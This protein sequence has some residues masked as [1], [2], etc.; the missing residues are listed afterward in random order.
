MPSKIEQIFKARDL[1]NKIFFVLAMLAFFR[2]AAHIPIP[3]VDTMKLRE[4]FAD[5]QAFGLLNLFSG[6]GMENFSIVTMGV[7]PYITASIIFQLLAMIVPKLEEMNK[8]EQGRAK[9]NQWTRWATIPIAILQSYSVIMLLKNSTTGVVSAMSPLSWVT[10][11]ATITAG[12]ILLMW[13]GELITEKKIGNGISIMIFAGIVSGLLG[14]LQQFVAT[15]D[16]SMIFT[17]ISFAVVAIAT[18]VGVVI[19]NEGQRNIPV[20]YARQ[21]RGARA[22]GGSSSHLP[23]RV[24]MAGVM[25]IIF[26]VSVITFPQMIAQFFVRSQSSWLSAM[27]GKLV[28]LSNN[29]LIYGILYFVLVFGFTYFYT[30]VVFHPKQIAENLQKQ[31]GFIPG[32]RPGRHTS[33][34]L[35]DTVHKVIFAGALFL[36]G[37]AV[38]PLLIK[39]WAGNTPGMTIGGTSILIVVSVV[40]ESVK[41]VE[42]QLSMREYDVM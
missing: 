5:N 31:G 35:S 2:L 40:I 4:F 3:S 19:I 23:L 13:I 29:G 1:R 38:M 14:Q 39:I 30:E 15:Y 9:I 16:P 20:Q 34:Y 18:V 27:A 24:N 36:A 11:I 6:G 42:A 10:A 21:I 26:A 32:I 41:Q 22:V 7:A 8:E 25:P 28:A 37:I 17:V 33:E 12:T